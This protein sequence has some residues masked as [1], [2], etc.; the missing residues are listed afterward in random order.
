MPKPVA[1][2]IS[3]RAAAAHDLL[4]GAS[5]VANARAGVIRTQTLRLPRNHACP[6]CGDTPSIHD[7]STAAHNL[8]AVSLRYFNVAGALIRPDGTEI[9]ERH[10]PETHLI[11]ITL[12]VAAGKREKHWGQSK[13]Y[14]DTVQRTD[15]LFFEFIR[16]LDG[17]KPR[18]F[19]A[20]NVSGL[21]KGVAKGYFLEILAK[22]KA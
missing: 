7:L 11:P 14:S 2:R 6:L 16:L 3:A 4:R 12:Q 1:Q 17:L 10:D 22:L 9:G 15:D 13:R 8:A 18:V 21:V 20:E 5:L 19:V